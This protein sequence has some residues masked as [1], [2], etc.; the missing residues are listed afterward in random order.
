MDLI[1]TRLELKA[2]NNGVIRPQYITGLHGW[3][4]NEVR[5]SNPELSQYLHDGQS[6]KPF[7]ISRLNGLELNT[8]ERIQISTEQ[9]YSFKITGLNS[10]VVQW[11]QE[12]VNN[13][14][15][16]I[17][18]KTVSW[19]ILSNTITYPPITYQSLLETPIEETLALTF[20]SPTSFRRKQHHF[21]LPLPFNVFQSYL[22]RWNDFANHP[23]DSETFLQWVDNHVIILRHQIQ[24]LKV[25]GGKKG[26]VTGFIGGVEYGLSTQGRKHQEFTQLFF[27]LGQLAPYCGTGHKTPF[28]LGQTRNGWFSNENIKESVNIG[29]SISKRIEELTLQ[30]MS[31]QKRKGGERALK[32]CQTRATIL[33][34][35]E[36]GESLKE[37]A[38]DMDIS[39]ETV[40]TYAKLARKL[41]N[42]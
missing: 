24:T 30:L 32:V 1:E 2:L 12:W 35:Q 15:D 28:G 39:Y 31:F 10:S 6:E 37:I 26:M 8:S 23:I 3:F 29:I 14:P 16:I 36:Q 19:E 40:K 11:L 42:S 18:Q 20:T 21:P 9:S 27:A 17:K 22:R 4:L 7:T 38:E 25:T 13:F 5:Q 33:A 41:L 34:R